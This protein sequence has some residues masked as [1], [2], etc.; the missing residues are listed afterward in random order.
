MFVLSVIS[1]CS[2]LIIT[3]TATFSPVLSDDRGVPFAFTSD[4]Y[5]AILVGTNQPDEYV[6][7]LVPHMGVPEPFGG[8]PSGTVEFIVEDSDAFTSQARKLGKFFFLQLM[9]SIPEK[10][11]KRPLHEARVKAIFT[12]ESQHGIGSIR[13]QNTSKV[14]V[15][16]L[17]RN[18]N[19]PFFSQ[20]D[21]QFS[22]RDDISLYE[23]FGKVLTTDADSGFNAQAFYYLDPAD[24]SLPFRVDP[25]TGKIYATRSLNKYTGT[26]LANGRNFVD[27]VDVRNYHFKIYATQRGDSSQ[28]RCNLVSVS[29]VHVN[30]IH[31]NKHAPGIIVDT[32]SDIVLPGISGMS[33]ARIS[34]VDKDSPPGAEHTLRIVEPDMREKFQVVPT[35]KPSEWLLQVRRNL[36]SIS[37]SARIVLTLEA[38]DEGVPLVN[39]QETVYSSVAQ[40]SY[41][42][43]NIPIV[44]KST[45]RLHFP[46]EVVVKISEAALPNCTVAI[47]RPDVPFSMTN[48]S[49]IYT[50]LQNGF[51][52]LFTDLPILLTSSG[53]VVLKRSVDVD[54]NTDAQYR[55]VNF[56]RIVIPFTTIDRNNLL[57]SSASTS[58]LVVEILDIN[59]NDPVVR[60]NGSVYEVSEDAAPGTLVLKI[61]AFDPD[62]SKTELVYALYDS[63][64]LPFILTHEG[65]LL[66][67]KPLDAETMPNEFTVYVWISD[68]GVPLPR[69][70]LAVFTVHILDVNEY[71][72]QFVEL[73]CK[74]WLS[75]TETGSLP[76]MNSNF[77]LGRYSAEDADRDKQNVVSI[78][79]ASSSLSRP[80]FKVDATTGE[81]SVVCS[82]LGSPNSDIRLTLLATDGTRMSEVPF[83][84]TIHL[85]SGPQNKSHFPENCQ[86][87]NVYDDLKNLR[88]RKNEYELLFKN[89]PQITSFGFNRHRPKFP[90]DLP[91]RLHIPENLPLYTAVLQFAVSD[92][93]GADYSLA[94]KVVYGVE[95]INSVP[96]ENFA[97]NSSASVS[98]LDVQQAFLLRALNF[99]DDALPTNFISP[100][101][102][103]E[104][105]VC[106]PLDR[107][108]ISSYSLILHACDLGSPQ[109]CASS[110]LHI[111]LE[112]LDDNPPEFSPSLP[113]DHTAFTPVD[114]HLPVSSRKHVPGVIM[115]PEDVPVDARIGQVTATDR[116]ITGEVRYRLITHTNMFKV[117]LG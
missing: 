14:R 35:G 58:Q 72:P 68:S 66:V 22:V 53:A 10:S 61:D 29:T 15:H 85:V 4:L 2:V 50:I 37:L 57:L 60:N 26:G 36:S 52:D 73:S 24:E 34:V 59:D 51:H 21:Y 79:L 87:S 43:V 7:P 16:V 93:D 90:S 23:S 28:V 105:V 13:L 39:R 111:F 86:Q 63:R 12:S 103:V 49:Y 94:G 1:A 104:L 84:L 11:R 106:A 113:E 112:D 32:F 47:L 67:D 6:I 65:E 69:S 40:K 45:Y 33:Y 20:L 110:Q 96:A 82:Y 48:F 99:V 83:E 80:C 100:P 46:N 64:S 76:N 81:L 88:L 8:N 41:Y 117:S 30:I 18:E 97:L 54:G 56:A 102:G 115:V 17:D 77:I 109:L 42:S 31:T 78:R 5:D 92:E 89:H 9:V 74:V 91:T 71:P 70:V 19:C 114:N 25:F 62:L 38:T 95:A 107:E 44:S 108:M 55:E 98:R 75:V 116:D 27:P 101:N 3:H